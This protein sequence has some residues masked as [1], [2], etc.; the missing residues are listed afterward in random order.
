MFSSACTYRAWIHDE[1][2]WN[3]PHRHRQIYY[4]VPPYY[5]SIHENLYDPC[6][7]S[8]SSLSNY[9]KAWDGANLG[10]LCAWHEQ[11]WHMAHGFGRGRGFTW[12][13]GDIKQEVLKRGN[14]TNNTIV[15]DSTLI[16]HWYTHEHVI[17]ICISIFNHGYLLICFIYCRN[18]VMTKL[19]RDTCNKVQQRAL[20]YFLGIQ[21]NT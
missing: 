16:S 21:S 3:L 9:Y 11:W 12:N 13:R 10:F 2:K 19:I 1:T 4:S 18:G 17:N 6:T 14:I 8:T 15:W 5:I 7:D 20:R